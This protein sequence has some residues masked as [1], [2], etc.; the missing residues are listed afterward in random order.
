M[1]LHYVPQ[2]SHGMVVMQSYG[3]AGHIIITLLL[4]VLRMCQWKNFENHLTFGK[5]MNNNKVG[6]FLAHSVSK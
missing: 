3:V 5:Y 6:R 2:V 1:L 4:T